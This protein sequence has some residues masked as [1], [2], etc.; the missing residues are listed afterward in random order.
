VL[1]WNLQDLAIA[2]SDEVRTSIETHV[3]SKRPTK[4]ILNGVDTD[5]FDL[6]R[7]EP[8]RIRL[9]LGIP[10][11]AP[12]VGTVAVFRSQ[13]RL[14]DWL[15]AA[16][17]LR[18]TATNVHFLIVGDG[19]LREEL[20]ERARAAGLD[21]SIHFPGLQ[22]DVRPYLAEMDVFLISSEFEGLP[23]ALL[24]AMSMQRVVVATAVGGIPE[25]IRNGENGVLVAPRD[26][27]ALSRAVSKTLDER[28][29]QARMGIDARSTVIE[30]FGLQRMTREI[31]DAYDEVLANR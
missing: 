30:R 16:R 23:V 8:S 31:E 12:I 5:H 11:G 7:C 4:V 15:E 2:V 10:A 28:E 21:G 25:V 26:P 22:D 1:S 6:A 3:R 19:P 18:A 29:N 9:E 17:M 13:K 24:E 27:H 14:Q 20:R